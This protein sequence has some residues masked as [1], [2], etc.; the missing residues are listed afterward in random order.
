ML[1][2]NNMPEANGKIKVDNNAIQGFFDMLDKNNIELEDAIASLERSINK[3]EKEHIEVVS[4]IPKCDSYKF[5]VDGGWL[6]IERGLYRNM[7]DYIKNENGLDLFDYFDSLERDCSGRF[8]I[9]S[10]EERATVVDGETALLIHEISEL[11]VL[12]NYECYYLVCDN[13][14]KTE[15]KFYK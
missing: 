9:V 8:R 13:D 11:I 15:T 10:Q 5:R 7:V 6:W 12:N 3:Q 4:I 14:S 1:E 2:M